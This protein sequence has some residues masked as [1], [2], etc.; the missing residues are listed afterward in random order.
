MTDFIAKAGTI[1]AAEPAA[2]KLTELLEAVLRTF[3][4]KNPPITDGLPYN[5]TRC[6]KTY[7]YQ[8]SACR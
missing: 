6:P 1:H 5:V 2:G 3:A 4:S 7:I 8:E